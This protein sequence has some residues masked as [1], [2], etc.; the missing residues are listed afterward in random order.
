MRSKFDF[1]P[2]IST[3]PPKRSLRSR[4]EKK[5]TKIGLGED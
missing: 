2:S 5:D 4:I 1:I 3:A